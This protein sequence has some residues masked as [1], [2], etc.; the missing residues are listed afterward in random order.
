MGLCQ[1]RAREEVLKSYV[2]GRLS[3]HDRDTF[4]EHYVG[5]SRCFEELQTCG[6]FEQSCG[7]T[8]LI[9]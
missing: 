5:C 9:F 2:L 6:P 4:E 1:G 7:R 8:A 3:N